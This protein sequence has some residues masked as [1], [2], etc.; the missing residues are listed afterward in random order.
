LFRDTRFAWTRN[1]DAVDR[2]SGLT[3]TRVRK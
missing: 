3:L 1:V 2:D